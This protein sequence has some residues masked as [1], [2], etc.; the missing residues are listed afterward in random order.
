M[1]S[2]IKRAEEVASVEVLDPTSAPVHRPG[3]P[4]A[5]NRPRLPA[6]LQRYLRAAGMRPINNVVD[7]TN[8]VMLEL[9]QPLHA[10]RLRPAR[11]WEDR[12]PPRPRRR[13]PYHDVGRSRARARS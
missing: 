7:I 9:G 6:W 13:E 12:R 11:R 10:F 5:E 3:D 8:F 1:R 2:P 4:T